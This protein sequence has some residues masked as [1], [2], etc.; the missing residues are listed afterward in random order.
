M[1]VEDQTEFLDSEVSSSN[2]EDN[3]VGSDEEDDFTES[4]HS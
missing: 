3:L 4:E 2:Q 1:S